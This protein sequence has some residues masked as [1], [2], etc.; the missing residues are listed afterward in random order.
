MEEEVGEEEATA[1]V[2]AEVGAIV[3]AV[4][5]VHHLKEEGDPGHLQNL[6]KHLNGLPNKFDMFLLKF[7]NHMYLLRSP[8][9]HGPVLECRYHQSIWL[10]LMA[11]FQWRIIQ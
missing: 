6:M 2:E 8:I 7:M 9:M 11:K 3:A 4:E 5:V 10:I 1:A